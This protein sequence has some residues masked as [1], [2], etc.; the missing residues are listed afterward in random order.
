MCDSMFMNTTG[1]PMWCEVHAC[2]CLWKLQDSLCEVHACDSIYENY[3][4]PYVRCMLV[5]LLWKLND[6]LCDVRYML[7]IVYE[8]YRI[9]YV[10]CML[11]I[12]LWKQPYSLCEVHACD[13]VMKTT[14][15]PMWGQCLWFCYENYLIPYGRCMLVILLL[16]WKLPDSLCEVNACDSVMKTTWF[17]MWG[18][19][20]WFCY[21]NYRIPHVRSILVIL[22]W[23]YRIPYV[24]C[25]PVI[26]LWK[27]QDS[28][29]T[30]IISNSLWFPTEVHLWLIF[31]SCFASW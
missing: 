5:I 18:A 11:V 25:M 2:D 3:R 31:C 1:F 9:P 4:I 10:R 24:R 8:N 7:V 16:L 19:C 27:L 17:P 30:C 12:L 21:E 23:N 15:F 26:L 13:S 29:W 28:Q 6:S 22:L 20:L 14:W